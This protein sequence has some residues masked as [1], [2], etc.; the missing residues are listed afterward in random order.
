MMTTGT[1]NGHRE[2]ATLLT[3]QQ[4]LRCRGRNFLEFLRSGKTEIDC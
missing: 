3:I 1:L 4:T 2:Y